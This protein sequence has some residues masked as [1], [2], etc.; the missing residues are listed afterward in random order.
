MKELLQVRRPGMAIDFSMDLNDTFVADRNARAYTKS[1]GSA[2][3]EVVSVMYQVLKSGDTAIDGGANIG[4]FSL[5]MASIVGVSGKV[6]A[7]EPGP[8]NWELYTKL[9][10]T[11]ATPP[12]F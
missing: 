3:P 7:F 12:D 11:L 2:E 8:N 10:K 4:Y 1:L 6:L 9:D 5:V